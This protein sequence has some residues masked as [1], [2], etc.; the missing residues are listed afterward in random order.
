MYFSL[1]ISSDFSWTLLLLGQSIEPTTCQMLM[2]LPEVLCTVKNV[3][4]V[5][6][7]LDGS[8]ICIGN[9]D[10]KF[11]DLLKSR[12]GTFKDQH[13]SCALSIFKYSYSLH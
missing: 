12:K 7:A 3:K 1:R 2:Q 4:A 5:I 6:R 13:G 10:G 9:N 11:L 8:S